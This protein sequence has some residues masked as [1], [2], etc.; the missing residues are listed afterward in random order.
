MLMNKEELAS[1]NRQIERERQLF[2]NAGESQVL[3]NT[4]AL[5]IWRERNNDKSVRH[6]TCSIPPIELLLDGFKGGELI[7]ISGF[8]GQGKTTLSRTLTQGLQEWG[9]RTMWLQYEETL[10]EFMRRFPEPKPTFYVPLTL[11]ASGL[12]WI[13]DRILEAILKYDIDAVFID[14]LHYL[15]DTMSGRNVSLEIG[16]VMRK[17]KM[18]AVKYNLPIFLIAHTSKPKDKEEPSLGSCRDSSFVEQ[19]ADTV[20]YVWRKATPKDENVVKVAKCRRN[21]AAMGEKITLKFRR[22]LLWAPECES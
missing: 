5:R 13:E 1:V 10:E 15:A 9:H 8:T 19:E 4:E 11:E 7:V 3:E 14:H 12:P 18:T 20:L 22:G 17:L 16:Q 2:E 6:L 21:G